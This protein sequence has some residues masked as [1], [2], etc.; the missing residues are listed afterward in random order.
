LPHNGVD[1]DQYILLT[2]Y[3]IVV[4]FAI[5]I[6][7]KKFKLDEALKYFFQGISCI[8]FA[9]FYII[10]IPRGGAQGLAIILILFGIL[11]F[12]MARKQKISP[13]DQTP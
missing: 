9:V 8:S 1:I 3:P 11:L 12:F 13:K 10:L 4:F 7:G 2:I 5:A 6:L